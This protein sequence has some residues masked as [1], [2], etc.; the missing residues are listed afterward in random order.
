MRAALGFAGAASLGG[1]GLSHAASRSE[2][3]AEK[4][5]LDTLSW[6]D[7]AELGQR[8]AEASSVGS[9][10]VALVAQSAGILDSSGALDLAQTKTFELADGTVARVRV[11][12]LAGDE[13][14]DGGVAGITFI[15]DTPIA[16]RGVSEVVSIEGGWRESGLRSWLAEDGLGLLPS[17]LSKLVRSVK[18]LTVLTADG[19]SETTDDAL[20][21]FSESEL[22]GRAKDSSDDVPY[23]GDA[24][25]LFSQGLMNADDFQT[26]FVRPSM[27]GVWNCWWERTLDFDAGSYAFRSYGGS[28]VQT[29][30]YSPNFELGVCP[31]FCL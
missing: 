18:K 22:G 29:I 17:D 8:V 23:E 30:G 2:S 16:A 14:S 7:L 5:A 13:L 28:R 3:A 20:W 4:T 1:C 6:S 25:Q 9:G 26:A 12:G 15:F 21:L 11:A 27:S 19:V 10:E 24:Y 31:G